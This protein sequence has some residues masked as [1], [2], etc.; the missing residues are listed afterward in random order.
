MLFVFLKS[1]LLKETGLHSH[2]YRLTHREGHTHRGGHTHSLT[3]THTLTLSIIIAVCLQ[4]W[5]NQFA[6]LQATFYAFSL[7]GSPRVELIKFVAI[8]HI[9]WH[10]LTHTHTHLCCSVSRKL[11]SACLPLLQGFFA[12]TDP[13]RFRYLFLTLKIIFLKEQEE[14]I[15]QQQEQQQQEQKQ[16]QHEQQQQQ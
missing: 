4:S 9:H 7:S 3:Y 2:I 11:V 10:I 1:C 16:Q 15:K 14:H 12:R 13:T 5:L 6:A 8:S